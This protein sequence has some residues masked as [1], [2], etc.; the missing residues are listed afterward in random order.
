LNLVNGKRKVVK[1]E[2]VPKVKTEGIEITPQ[3][4]CALSCSVGICRCVIF[5][6]GVTFVNPKL[7][8]ALK[9]S[10]E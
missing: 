1:L 10:P 4:D 8:I 3:I 6:N 7:L 5:K 9:N 2:D